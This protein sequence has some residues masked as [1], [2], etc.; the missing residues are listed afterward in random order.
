MVPTGVE[1]LIETKGKVPVSF[2]PVA[3]QYGSF[4]VFLE[5]VNCKA[6]I[7]LAI[8]AQSVNEHF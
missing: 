1:S 3:K 2:R 8:L 5:A 7:P 4:H 6:K